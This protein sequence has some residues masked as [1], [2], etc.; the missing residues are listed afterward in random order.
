M[1]VIDSLR[2]YLGFHDFGK[3]RFLNA[4]SCQVIRSCKRC[5]FIEY[6]HLM[7]SYGKIE[8]IANTSCIME[9]KCLRCGHVKEKFI[10]HIFTDWNVV[11]S[12]SCTRIKTCR[13]CGESIS[14]KDK[15]T[16]GEFKYEHEHNCQ[17]IR[18]CQLCN[19]VEAGNI[20][21]I[22]KHVETP[23]KCTKESKCMRCGMVCR[24]EN[25]DFS[26]E[27]RIA[28]IKEP[29]EYGMNK[30]C[31]YCGTAATQE[32]PVPADV[33]SHPHVLKDHL[34]IATESHISLDR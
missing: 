2:C 1:E 5:N 31:K 20:E 22:W 24:Q 25:H 17:K 10:K 4:N 28:D 11:D 13:R 33:I 34:K 27:T 9:N 6:A 29:Y 18:I 26:I 8:Y 23:Y 3:F 7:H 15:H 21:H 12:K 32:M 16:F 19:F 14:D 30:Y